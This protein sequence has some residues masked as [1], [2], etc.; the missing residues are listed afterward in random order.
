MA[1]MKKEQDAAVVPVDA[2]ASTSSPSQ[3]SFILPILPILFP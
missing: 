1:R 3:P 2:L